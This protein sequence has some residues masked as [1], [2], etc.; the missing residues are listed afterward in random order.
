M[1]MHQIINHFCTKIGK[2]PLLVQGAGGNISWKEENTLWI[3]A[4]GTALASANEK[5]IFIPL[6][7][8]KTR[9]LVNNNI[10][11]FNSARLTTSSLRPSIETSFHALL[12][13]KI[14]VHLHLVDIIALAI[15]KDAKY[16][17]EHRLSEFNWILIDY[18]KPGIQ[19]A[20]EITKKIHNI[21]PDIIILKNHGLIIAGETIEIIQDKLN[22]LLLRCK[23]QPRAIMQ[24]EN[25][26]LAMLATDWQLSD[27]QLPDN[28]KLH[29]LGIDPVLQTIARQKWV[30]YPDHA[31]F[32][33]ERA[34]FN[35][36]KNLE[37]SPPCIIIEDKG[38]VVHK[39]ISSGQTAMLEC[40]LNVVS[41][42]NNPMD[43]ESLNSD[44][45]SELINWDAEKYRQEIILTTHI[46][47]NV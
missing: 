33:G 8:E 30:L 21:V 13:Q 9:T 44:Q 37:H 2:N 42:I 22:T 5:N 6:D 40:Y 14:V 32:L 1:N 29:S 17:F 23:Q 47:E 24:I 18:F 26:A 35:D 7:L 11:D 39:H 10:D 4:S 15:L 20:H 3:K 43:I 31:V 36:L 12:P 16:H 46:K 28:M 19:L 25:D 27:Y 34:L 41:R 38:I 45:I